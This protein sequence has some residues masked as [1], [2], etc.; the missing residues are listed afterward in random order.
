MKDIHAFEP[1]WENWVIDEEIGQG[2]YGTVWKAHREDQFS[3]IRQ[4]AAVK[5]ISIPKQE[6]QGDDDIPFPSEEARS[7]YYRSMLNQLIVE[8]D[9]MVSLRGKPNIVSYEEHKVVP[10]EQN[11]GYDLFLRME[12]LTSIPKYIKKI[13]KRPLYRSEVIQLGIDIATALETLENRSFVHRD[14][15]PD[16]IFIDDEGNFKLGDFG[17]ARVLEA[18]G[19]ASTKTGTPNYMAPEVYTKSIH[20]DQTVDIY[21]LG[22]M[23]Y[24]YMNNGYLPFTSQ[25]EVAPEPALIKRIRGEALPPPCNADP[26][27]SKVILK[28]CAFEPKNRYQNAKNLKSDLIRCLKTEPREVEIPVICETDDGVELFKGYKKAKAGSIVKITIDDIPYKELTGEDKQLISARE[29]DISID[30]EGRMSPPEARFIWNDCKTLLAVSVQIICRD[31]NHNELLVQKMD[32]FYQNR[33]IAKAPVIDGYKPIGQTEIEVEVLKNRTSRPPEVVFEY[34]KAGNDIPASVPVIPAE[35]DVPVVCM[36]ENGEEILNSKRTC[37]ENATNLVTAPEITGYVLAGNGNEE[38]KVSSDGKASPEKVVFTYKKLKKEIRTA[39]ITVLCR[40]DHGNEIQKETIEGNAGETL[41][42]TASEI[43]GYRLV[44]E[45]NRSVGL[46]IDDNGVPAQNEVVF[47]YEKVKEGNRKWR[48]PAIIGI[49]AAL[50]LGAAGIILFLPRPQE[51][52]KITWVNE[53]GTVIETDNEVA[54]D[55]IPEYN[56]KTPAKDDDEKYSYTFTG[57]NPELK[58]VSSDTEYVAV[59]EKTE[60]PALI[61]PVYTPIPDDSTILES[62]ENKAVDDTAAEVPTPV[63]SYTITWVYNKGQTIDTTTVEYGKKP[64]HDD[65]SK[66]SDE[67]YDYTFAGWS[68]KI[69]EAT[70][71]RIY[72]ATFNGKIRSYSITWLDDKGETIDTT[73]VTYGRKPIHADAAKDSDEQYSYTFEGWQPEISA[74]TEDTTYKASFAPV[75]RS[76]TITWKDDTGDTFDT[77]TVQYGEKPTPQ[78]TPAKKADEQYIY[79]FSGWEPEIKTV[80]G[81][82]TYKASFTKTLKSYTI[83]WQ[84]DTGKTIDTTAV[85]YGEKPTHSDAAKESDEQYDYSFAGWAPEIETVTG[86]ATYKA[87]FTKTLKSY[88]ITWQ[89]DTGKTID[90]TAVEYGEKPTHADVTK[91]SDEQNDYTFSG[92]VPVIKT[93]TGDATYKASFTKIA[94]AKK[95]TITWQDDERNTLGTTTVNAG[96]KPTRENPTKESNAKYSYEFVGWLPSI[97]EATEDKTY[98]ASFKKVIRSYTITW[99][100]DTGKTIDTTTVEYGVMPSHAYPI[101]EADQQ[102]TYTFAGWSPAVRTVTGDAT[103]VAIYNKTQVNTEGWTCSEC[104]KVNSYEDTF[105]TNCAKTRLCLECGESVLKDDKYCTHCATEAGKWKCS[106]CGDL[107]K[108]DNNFCEACGTK[109]HKPGEK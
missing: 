94:K 103:Y 86:D 3:H 64:T 39:R 48:K 55:S 74:A 100:D 106:K 71:D 56:G 78:K 14:I 89:D 58:P 29:I 90:T 83:T 76:Y 30:N 51:T 104:K 23:L 36:L 5:H 10:K 79:T 16:N 65:V 44:N 77:T 91:E 49:V 6:G 35:C 45:N 32:C 68:P 67:Q 109:R 27:L 62:T 82:A 99:Q 59:F 22:I 15:K 57:W 70:E 19:N 46:R 8:I 80:T 25:T 84:D 9:A 1:I 21:S 34:R 107:N 12:L 20:Y 69:K 37:R 41:N 66:E 98:K 93:V 96:E 72:T 108:S 92:W 61:S 38:I 105:C 97:K 81:D 73:S 60:K 52:Y 26:E 11:S 102:Y 7:R 95:Y 47:V 4:Y 31:E 43:E 75:I 40:D 87:S 42:I 101:K 50:L 63:P 13:I 54:A 53:D 2:S 18:S 28:A 17:T 88:T 33:N 24:R 85:E